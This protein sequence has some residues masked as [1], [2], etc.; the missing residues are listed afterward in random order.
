MRKLSI[1]PLFVFLF[2]YI[3]PLGVR[4]LNIPDE[5][6]YAEISREMIETGDFVVPR[7]VGLRYFEKPVMGY[8]L[9]AAA[10]KVFGENNFSVRFASA[11]SVGLSALMLFFLARRFAGGYFAGI[12]SS[13]I[14]LTCFEVFGIGVYSVLDSMFAF[15]IIAAMICFYFACSDLN[16]DRTRQKNL[17]L[18]FCGVF[19]GFAFLTKGFLAVVL[20]VI[21][22]A[23][24]LIWERRWKD[25]FTV[26]WIPLAAA[27]LV[28]MPWAVMVHLRE[29]DFWNYFFWEE[30]IRRF[31]ADDAQHIAPF[32]YYLLFFPAAAV[33]WT[34]FA[35]SIFQGLRKKKKENPLFKF[36]IC[37]FVFP[38]LF[39]SISKGKLLTYILPCFV[40]FALLAAAGLLNC[41]HVEI[42][43]KADMPLPKSFKG[44][45]F[46][47]AGFFG[48]V[49]VVLAI[50]QTTDV[51]NFR[52]FTQSWKSWLGI[53]ACF[54]SVV[55]YLRAAYSNNDG[56]KQIV[57]I[58]LAPILFMFAAHF[59]YP[60]VVI[61]KKSPGAFL[62]KHSE[63]IRPDTILVSDY[64]PIK[65]VC[66]YY[67]RTD[68]FLMGSTGELTYGVQYPDSAKRL[69]DLDKLNELISKNPGN[70][71]FVARMNN[72]EKWESDL[73]KPVF[74]D[75]NGKFVFAM[76]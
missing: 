49:A 52:P 40:P 11:C 31:S 42:G 5:T 59:L 26:P 70:L 33:P 41:L 61:Y 46:V 66:W 71:V 19:V 55:F 72:F 60:D 75:V 45:A 56:R 73:P 4:P 51:F 30:H 25:L 37:W 32:Y 17:F 36:A 57:F 47:A 64:S 14:F 43:K 62:M 16:T 20:P 1:L 2:L 76:F 6:R 68:V 35:P 39:F 8:W 13:M 63:K 7:L 12:V 50:M 22:I 54:A 53:T 15:F 24:F 10:M 38:F 67:K 3:L 74:A 18:I 21:I 65:A 23:P 29:P 28:I 9:N 44:G 69:L 27:A 48:I 34:F 58:A